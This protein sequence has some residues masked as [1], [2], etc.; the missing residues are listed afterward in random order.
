[1]AR[2]RS[3]ASS[4]AV[5]LPGLEGAV[6]AEPARARGLPAVPAPT[7]AEKADR[8]TLAD[9]AAIEA[10][11]AAGSKAKAAAVEADPVF[12]AAYLCR[13]KVGGASPFCGDCT[14]LLSPGEQAAEIAARG[15]PG[16]A[17]AVAVARGIVAWRKGQ[18][19]PSPAEE[20][21]AR[22]EERATAER[23]GAMLAT[24]PQLTEFYRPG[25]RPRRWIAD[26]CREARARYEAEVAVI[27]FRRRA[28]MWLTRSASDGQ[29]QVDIVG[30]QSERA[31][32]VDV[33][34]RSDPN[35]MGEDAEREQAPVQVWQEEHAEMGVVED[36]ADLYAPRLDDADEE[37]EALGGRDGDAADFRAA[38]WAR[39]DVTGRGALVRWGPRSPRFDSR[40]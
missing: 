34:L 9:L 32:A 4:A 12:C 1:M 35:G 16:H 11:Q 24:V 3:A 31:T 38:A 25:P 28:R 13:A 18:R 21:A 29:A 6:R 22:E 40:A 7:V 27:G 19:I 2:A 36:E 26:R 15:T 39:L 23:I 10:A 8:L 17:R 14:A 5:A 30:G 20:R 37:S 33:P